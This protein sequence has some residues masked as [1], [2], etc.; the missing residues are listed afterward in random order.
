MLRHPAVVVVTITSAISELFTRS[1]SL[2]WCGGSSTTLQWFLSKLWNHIMINYVGNSNLINEKDFHKIS[3]WLLYVCATFKL[4]LQYMKFNG[5]IKRM[6]ASWNIVLLF[7]IEVLEIN[8]QW[9]IKYILISDT[10]V[11]I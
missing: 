9:Q 5:N 7:C 10:Y 8:W 6:Y 2:H 4:D 11:A 3:L 1:W